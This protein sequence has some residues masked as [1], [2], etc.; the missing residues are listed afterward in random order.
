[1]QSFLAAVKGKG[2]RVSVLFDQDTHVWTIETGPSEASQLPSRNELLARVSAFKTNL[3]VSPERITQIERET[4]EQSQSLLWYVVR[5]CRL[6]ASMF[7][8][9]VQ[10]LPST[11]PDSLVK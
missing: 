6:T 3:H 9:V 4:I 2:L 5:R 10:R 8:K 1:M 7:G 11:P